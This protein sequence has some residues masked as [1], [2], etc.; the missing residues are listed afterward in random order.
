MKQSNIH[1]LG[2]LSADNLLTSSSFPSLLDQ[3]IGRLGVVVLD[4]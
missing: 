3:S 4:G 2:E 1:K